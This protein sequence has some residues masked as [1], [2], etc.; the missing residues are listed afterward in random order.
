MQPKAPAAKKAYVKPVA[1]RIKLTPSEAVLGNCKTSDGSSA[2][3]AQGSCVSPSS[4][5]SGG[6]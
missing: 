1:N 2:G 3:P 4:C 5:Y 6:S